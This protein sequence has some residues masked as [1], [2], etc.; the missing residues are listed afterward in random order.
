MDKKIKFNEVMRSNQM[1]KVCP[2]CNCDI[3][4]KWESA[5]N[6]E[7]CPFCGCNIDICKALGEVE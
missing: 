5:Y 7:W 4:P 3:L 6:K 2:K 1:V